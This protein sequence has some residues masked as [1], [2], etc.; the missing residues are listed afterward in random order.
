[1]CATSACRD[2]ECCAAVRRVGA[3]YRRDDALDR[4]PRSRREGDLGELGAQLQGLGVEAADAVVDRVAPLVR[5]LNGVLHWMREHAGA[6]DSQPELTAP[7]LLLGSARGG[8]EISDP[9]F[10]ER[11]D[12]CFDELARCVEALV[13]ALQGLRAP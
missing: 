12:E 5:V 4:Q 3:R 9:L 2:C 7:C 10:D 8:G 13:S 1:M 6:M 11:Y